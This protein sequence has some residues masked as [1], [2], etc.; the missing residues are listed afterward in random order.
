MF[1]SVRLSSTRTDESGR[2]QPRIPVAA[3]GGS[4]MMTMSD[5]GCLLPKLQLGLQQEAERNQDLQWSRSSDVAPDGCR[6]KYEQTQ[7]NSM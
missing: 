6:Q 4:R 5:D 7:V 2:T 1:V 3:G